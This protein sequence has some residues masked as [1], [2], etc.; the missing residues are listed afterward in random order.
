MSN[1]EQQGGNFGQMSQN[2][3]FS[4]EKGQKTRKI[5]RC[6]GLISDVENKGEFWLETQ[7]I[8]NLGE[9]TLKFVSLISTQAKRSAGFFTN[10]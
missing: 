10:Y 1:V 7:L 8:I 4:I 2:P 9:G 6:G 5:F 3:G